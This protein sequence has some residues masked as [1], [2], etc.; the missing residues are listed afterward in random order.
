MDSGERKLINHFVAESLSPAH[1][2]GRSLYECR[3]TD[4]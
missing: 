3:A 1:L 4:R 2:I